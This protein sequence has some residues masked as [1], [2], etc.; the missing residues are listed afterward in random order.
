M[1]KNLNRRQFLT[2]GGTVAAASVLAACGATPTATP[3]KVPPTATKAPAAPTAAPAAPTAAPA[4]PTAVPPTATKAPAA[5]TAAPAAKYKEAPALADLV[6][7]GKLPAVDQRLPANPLVLKPVEKVG[8]YGGTW[9]SALR[10]GADDAWLTRTIG[11]DYL[12][13]WDP[14]WTTVIPCVGESYTASADAKEYTFKLRKGMKWSDGKPFTADDIVFWA[15]DILNNKE[16]TPAVGG[17]WAAGGKYLTAS[18]VDETT[19]K[20][21]FTAPNG[22][23]IVR[24]ATP[25]GQS[26][27]QFQAAYCKQFHKGYAD[28][29]KLDALI[30]ENKQDDW[31]KLFGMKCTSITGTPVNGRWQNIDLPV[32]SAWYLT[33]PSGTQ[34][35]CKAVRNPYYWKVD[36]EG[37]QLPYLDGINY[38]YVTDANV[39]ALKAANGEI[40]MMDR[41]IATNANKPVFVQNMQKGAYSFFETIPSS[42]NNMI[43]SF[44]LTHKNKDMRAIFQ[45]I[46]FRIGLSYAI[47]RKEII[48]TVWVGQGEPYQLAPRPTSPYYNEKLAKQYTEF[49]LKK[50][51]EYLDKAL[52]K[53]DAAGMRLGPDG[54]T[55]SFT[56]EISDTRTDSV[57][58]APLVQKTW[59]QVGIDVII[60]VEDRA[61]MY[62]R[63]DAADFDA[64]DWGGD[65]GLDVVLEPRWYFPYS[66]ESQFGILWQ[67]WW[68]K[69]ARGEEPPAA[70]KKQQELY[71]EL[72]ASGDTKKQDELMKQILQ[73]AQEQFW[74]IG[75]VLPTNGYGIVKNNFKNVQKVMP[76]AWLFPNPGPSD[77]PQYFID[78]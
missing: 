42:M 66:T 43:I 59:K 14:N 74:A 52:P 17:S 2:I 75:I 29:A 36:T 60:K 55:F 7:A 51:A 71:D 70:P 56:W 38:D 11:Y 16:L 69:D 68:R 57:A 15:T 30:K 53:K 61:L 18:K 45:D 3:T 41:H 33:T 24:N 5:P 32:I 44:N 40:D 19:V 72:Q 49:D 21:T 76:G 48:D 63:K 67:Y 50:A 9:R 25:D 26:P 47:N 10:G 31:V 77:P 46:N 1:S 34:N 23:F 73:I 62:T 12:V 39:L 78:A 58:A 64:M 65:G 28:A 20:F 22:L 13:R 37:N 27:V 35:P 8:K 54:K 6:K 4:A